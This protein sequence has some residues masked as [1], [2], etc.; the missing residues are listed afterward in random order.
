ML[1]DLVERDVDRYLRLV[2]RLL[3]GRVVGLYVVG[4]VALGAYRRARSDIDLVVVCD[5]DLSAA[6]QRKVRA[7][8]WMSSVR[9]APP[10]LLRADLS[11]PGTV[12]ATYVRS[13]DLTKPVTSIEPLCTHVGHQFLTGEG[14]DVNPVQW[15]TLADHGIAVRGDEPSRLGLDPEPGALREWNLRNLHGYWKPFAE[16]LAARGPGPGHRFRPRWITAW[17]V[18]GAP[19]LHHTIATGEV[20]SKE[21]A[22]EY[23]LATF[24]QR[25]HPV[26]EEGLGYWREETERPLERRWDDTAAFV[27]E[28]VRSAGPPPTGGK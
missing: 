22:G 24:D 9:T 3:P 11:V 18:L 19:R 17:G 28:V 10:A 4:S 8:Q 7:V 6:E 12:N 16:R 1:P 15:K 27:L 21:A 25:W 26:I 2:D 14:F 13:A 20:I 23:A 5:G